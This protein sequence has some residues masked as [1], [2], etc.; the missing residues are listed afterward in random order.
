MALFKQGMVVGQGSGSIGGVVLSH[1]RGGNYIRSLVFPVNPKS[2]RQNV[3]RQALSD[4]VAAWNALTDTA[5]DGWKTYANAIPWPSRIG[6]SITLTGAQMFRSCWCAAKAAGITPVTTPPA[7]LVR[8]GLD[9]TVAATVD[10]SDHKVSVTFDNTM[11]WATA[12]GGH[13]AIYMSRPQ[14]P[15]VNFCNGPFTFLG[16]VDGAVVAPTSPADFTSLPFTV[17]AGQKIF[18]KYRLINV[19][20]RVSPEGFFRAVVVA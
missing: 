7:T 20:G 4:A 8:P 18:F 17:S 2:S 14:G 15:T 1:N 6:I 12:V 13:M 19:D 5:R 16:K 9:P 11:A 10:A 3:V